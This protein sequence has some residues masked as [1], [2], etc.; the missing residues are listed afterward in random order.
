MGAVKGENAEKEHLQA[1][2]KR[3][4]DALKKLSAPFDTAQAEHLAD[5]AA[6]APAMLALADLTADFTRRYQSE[7]ARRNAMDF[8]DQEHYAIELLLTDDGQPT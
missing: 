1:V 7:K 8:S 4:K 5:L 3:C 2:V 6:M